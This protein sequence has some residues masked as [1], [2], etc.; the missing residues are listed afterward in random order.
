MAR[1]LYLFL[2]FGI[3][4]S[5]V[6]HTI[7][8][9]HY[10]KTI[11]LKDYKSLRDDGIIKQDLDY[12]CGAASIATLLNNYFYQNT[13]EE[14]ILAIMDKGD[15]KA[16]FLDMQRAL[17]TLGFNS[18]GLAVSYDTLKTLKAPAIVYIKHRKTDHFSVIR[19]INE[20]FVWLAD[21]S[22]GNRVLSK[23]DFIKLWH[24]RE[25]K[26][27]SG[28]ILAVIPKSGQKVNNDY[29]TNVIKQPNKQSLSMIGYF[30]LQ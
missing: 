22:L 20:N 15:L 1:L 30:G 5:A 14:Q 8:F 27:L 2:V 13:T 4:Q 26:I 12:S 9:N 10:Q 25:D 17:T 11:H 6:A 24:T 7:D 3:A 28:K 21:P 19:G 23:E 29:F 18:Q 16:S